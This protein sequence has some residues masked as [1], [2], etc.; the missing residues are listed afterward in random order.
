[1]Q[2]L[3]FS[4]LIDNETYKGRF[5][6]ESPSHIV[7][8]LYQSKMTGALRSYADKGV[9][10]LF[11]RD[12]TPVGVRMANN[13]T[14]LGHILHELKIIDDAQLATAEQVITSEQRVPLQYFRD[15]GLLNDELE[16]QIKQMQAQREI[17]KFAESCVAKGSATEFEWGQGISFLVGFSAAWI[18]IEQVVYE[19]LRRDWITAES[20]AFLQN[21]GTR[22]VC[23]RGRLPDPVTRFGFGEKESEFLK[24]I[25][26]WQGVDDL[27]KWAIVKRPRIS[28][29]LR[30]IDLLGLLDVRIKPELSN[31][32]IIVD[33]LAKRGGDLTPVRGWT[34]PSIVENADHAISEKP[35]ILIDR[36]ALGIPEPIPEK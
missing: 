25:Q 9:N 2:Q 5:D 18:P 7:S 6:N 36:A 8:R 22:Q 34:D 24:A 29:I 3:V 15:L 11:F 31:P 10:A 20:E 28:F 17:E 13:Q 19:T 27:T 21:F 26:N 30:F 4:D 32:R 35:S 12:G 1:M 33:E 16:T 14:M 23:L